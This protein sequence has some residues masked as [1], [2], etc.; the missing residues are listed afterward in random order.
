MIKCL[1]ES[2]LVHPENTMSSA[3]VPI[4]TITEQPPVWGWVR[5]R[6]LVIDSVSSPHSRRVYTT[7]IDDFRRW[8]E[9]SESRIFTRET[10]QQYRV[11]LES[12]GMS[13][14]TVNLHLTV[15]RKLAREAS[16]TGILSHESAAKITDVK[17]RRQGAK[18]GTW[19]TSEQARALLESP[20][21]DSLRGKRD[22]ALLALLL[23]CGLHRG[24]VAGLTWDR[25]EEREGRWVI[26]DIEGKGSRVR[27][28]PM[29]TWAKGS[30]DQW[31]LAADIRNGK[32][33]RAIAQN[34]NIGKGLSPQAVYLIV[35][36]YAEQIRIR[37]T[38]HDLR[39]TFAKLAHRGHSPLEQIQMSLGHESIVTTERYLNVRQNLADAPCDH[40]GLERE[41]L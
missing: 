12:R 18:L 14:S 34:G 27:N 21:R 32:L 36:G 26:V 4:T 13:A 6:A 40:L 23:G 1:I 22:R 31:T 2:G 9:R 30:L 19:L 20:S 15:L 33:F 24:E 7:A 37:I 25:V 41:S 3:P 35:R 17:G 10:V 28:V 16:L 29:P 38:P 8:S 5:A 11:H 39:R